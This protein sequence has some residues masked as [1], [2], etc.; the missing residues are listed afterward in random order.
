MVHGADASVVS[1]SK[2]EHLPAPNNQW[3]STTPTNCT[4]ASSGKNRLINRVEPTPTTRTRASS[5]RT[6]HTFHESGD[7]ISSQLRCV[8]H[9]LGS[10]QAACIS[11]R[12]HSRVSSGVSIYRSLGGG[13]VCITTVIYCVH[14][15]DLSGSKD[16][17]IEKNI[18]APQFFS[19][20]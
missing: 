13:T 19:S 1:N 2:T 20:S 8:N 9:L 7:F 18:T 11:K 4:P 15:R 17:S 10:S 12:T 6:G 14:P 3:A 16:L 5:V